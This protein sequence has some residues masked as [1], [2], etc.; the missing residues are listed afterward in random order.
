MKSEVPVSKGKCHREQ[1]ERRQGDTKGMKR[2]KRGRIAKG[3]EERFFLQTQIP[4]LK[5]ERYE[6]G[7]PVAARK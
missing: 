7:R 2:E 3:E 5:R 6:R 4:S 1:V